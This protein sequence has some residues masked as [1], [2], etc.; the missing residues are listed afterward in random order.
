MRDIGASI[1]MPDGLSALAVGKL[2]IAKFYKYYLMLECIYDRNSHKHSL[3]NNAEHLK[4]ISLTIHIKP[5]KNRT[6]WY[7]NFSKLHRKRKP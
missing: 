7:L 2:R 1:E 4:V 5:V 3:Q 6:I